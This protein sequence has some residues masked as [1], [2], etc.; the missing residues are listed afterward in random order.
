M[1]WICTVVHRDGSAWTGREMATQRKA[2]RRKCTASRSKGHAMP[3]LA[4]QRICGAMRSD[5]TDFPSD[6][7][8]GRKSPGAGASCVLS[9]FT[10]SPA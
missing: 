7:E 6:P 10:P 4:Q 9:H 8:Y 5:G 1:T 2:Q 3:R